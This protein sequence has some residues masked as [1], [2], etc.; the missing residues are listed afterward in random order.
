MFEVE[1][2]IL[3]M[4]D[5]RGA[6]VK[7]KAVLRDPSF[8]WSEEIVENRMKSYTKV[9]FGHCEEKLNH[10]AV[11]PNTQVTVNE[12]GCLSPSKTSCSKWNEAPEINMKMTKLHYMPLVLARR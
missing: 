11:R 10:K 1:Q 6:G 8:R 2:K 12:Q 7:P 9:E 4:R 3:E 5:Q